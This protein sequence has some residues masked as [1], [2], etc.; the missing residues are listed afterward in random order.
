MLLHTE[1]ILLKLHAKA[2]AI[3]GDAMA[4]KFLHYDPK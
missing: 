1:L 3:A 2:F 4:I